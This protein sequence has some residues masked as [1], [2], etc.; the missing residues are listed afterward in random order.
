MHVAQSID[1]AELENLA[2]MGDHLLFATED[3]ELVIDHVA[4][5]FQLSGGQNILAS[6]MRDGTVDD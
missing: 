4:V 1:L 5:V 6:G 3:T 2:I